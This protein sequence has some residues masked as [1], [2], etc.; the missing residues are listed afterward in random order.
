MF[1]D[2]EK[3]VI[4]EEMTVSRSNTN[5]GSSNSAVTGKNLLTIV[6]RQSP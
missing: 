2:L 4:G 3:R 6:V 1:T 5:A